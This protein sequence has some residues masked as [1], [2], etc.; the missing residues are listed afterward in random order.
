MKK[1]LSIIMVLL[2]TVPTNAQKDVTTFLGIPV[3]GTKAAMKSKLIEKGFTYN[4]ELDNFE[5]EFNGRDVNVSIVTNNNK[6]YRILIVDSYPSSETQIKLR[7][8]NLCYQF[9]NNKKYVPVDITKEPFNYIIP[10]DEDISYGMK[11]KNKRYDAIFT[12]SI[13]WELVDSTQIQREVKKI[14]E[15]KYTFEELANLTDAQKSDLYESI[16][17]EIPIRLAGNVINKMV[18]FCILELNGGY[19]IAMYYDNKYNEA[20]GEDL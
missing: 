3:D 2:M 17:K 16:Y 20:N 9:A 1:F 12:Q 7:F 10:D 5:G 14:V 13:N 8:N 19:V 11:V 15:D 6:V 4:R 18:W